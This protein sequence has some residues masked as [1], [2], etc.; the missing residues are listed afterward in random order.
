MC[1]YLLEFFRPEQDAAQL[2]LK[3]SLYLQNVALNIE[4]IVWPL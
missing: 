4:N 2:M 3:C 1:L